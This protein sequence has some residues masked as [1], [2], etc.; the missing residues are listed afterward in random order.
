MA[1]HTISLDEEGLVYFFNQLGMTQALY[2]W[3]L[4]HMR[5][6]QSIRLE[7]LDMLNDINVDVTKN[8]LE[9]K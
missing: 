9:I 4:E 1:R 5:G 2:L 8:Y 6:A 7:S 3:A